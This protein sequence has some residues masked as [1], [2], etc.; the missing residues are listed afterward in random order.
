MPKYEP[1]GASSRL[2][3]FQ[4]LP[5]LRAHGLIVDVQPLLGS[6]YLQNVYTGKRS[7]SAIARAYAKR[8]YTMVSQRNYDVLWIEKEVFP[9]LPT[10]L[11]SAIAPAR[12]KWLVDYDDAVF[13]AYDMHRSAIVRSLLGNNIDRVMQRADMVTAG[14]EYLADRARSAGCRQVEI[15][16][17]VIDLERYPPLT[18]SSEHGE[19]VIGWIG[20]PSSAVHLQLVARAAERLRK[21][22]GVKFIAV[23]APPRQVAGTPFEAV[24]WS[25]STEVDQLRG[26]SIGIMPLSDRLWERGKCG[27]KLIQYMACGLPVVASPVGVN[28]DIVTQGTNGYLAADEEEWHDALVD[29]I[30]SQTLRRN[31]GHAGRCIVENNYC[32]Q[33]QAPRLAGFLW[34]LAAEARGTGNP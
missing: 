33:V 14:N 3:T 5:Y 19:I 10:W 18:D 34:Q 23:G 27:Y 4:Y 24:S 29:L 16:P 11:A 32:L 30:E 28:K 17:T 7:W 31:L 15:I 25:E 20:S 12:T 26:F 6:E 21:S 9:W 2:R 1:L 8:I 13:H 22:H